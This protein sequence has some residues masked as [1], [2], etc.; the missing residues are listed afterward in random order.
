MD[1]KT[2][3]AAVKAASKLKTVALPVSGVTVHLKP[4]T[5][6]QADAFYAESYDADGK[7]TG[8][9]IDFR[10]AVVAATVCDDK[11][12]LILKPE[13]LGAF[14]PRDGETLFRAASALNTV[15]EDDAK[16]TEKN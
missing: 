8:S 13:D 5:I 7:L 9:V 2:L 11:G 3:M 1:R 4:W 6:A 12:E 10:N 14:C 16:A 15:T